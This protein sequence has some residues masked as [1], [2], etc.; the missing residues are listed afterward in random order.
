MLDTLG[1]GRLSRFVV[2][3]DPLG[4]FEKKYETRNP[5]IKTNE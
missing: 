2:Q 5:F 4:G 3:L 1:K